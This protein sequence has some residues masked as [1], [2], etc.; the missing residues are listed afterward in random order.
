MKR[1]LAA[2]LRTV[3]LPRATLVDGD[4]QFVTSMHAVRHYLRKHPKAERIL[5]GAANDPSA[6]GA[7]RAF[8]EAGRTQHCAVIG[9]NGQLEARAELRQPSTRMIGSVA[10]FPDQYG[11]QIVRF[12]LKI[13]EQGLK[14]RREFTKHLLITPENVNEHYPHDKLDQV[15]NSFA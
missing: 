6:L 1:G 15:A 12:A 2:T 13:L 10:F 11:N 8:Q 3:N 4:G 14:E 9:L 7:L 5:V